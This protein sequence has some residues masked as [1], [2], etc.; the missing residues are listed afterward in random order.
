MSDI[1]YIIL[2]VI[3]AYLIGSFPTAIL[4]GRMYHGIDIRKSGSGNAG[5]TNTFR[6]LGKKAGSI[7]MLID[8]FK[9]WLATSC[10]LV[11]LYFSVI[12]QEHLDV[13]KL[14][15]GLSAVAGHIFPVYEQFKGGKGIATL[16]GMLM[17]I[18]IE[19]ALICITV[20]CI[21][22]LLSKYVSLGSMISTLAFPVMLLI[23]PRF[24]PNDPIIIVFGFMI[25]LL[26]VYTHKKNIKRLLRGEENKTLIRLRK[27]N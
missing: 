9:G 16:L 26:V 24:R 17:S 15:F 27:K 25:F 5:A 4:Y 22:L 23:I 3:S 21:V 6:V 1:L 20:F 10:T 13:Y 7:V 12:T 19:A 14:I 18:Q 2:G 8:V 11:L